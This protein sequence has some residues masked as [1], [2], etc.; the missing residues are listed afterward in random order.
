[1]PAFK[2]DIVYY[3]VGGTEGKWREAFPGVFPEY[4]SIDELIDTITRAGYHA[5]RG[6]KAIGA[7]EGAP[8]G[9]A[10]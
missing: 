4:K 5:V 10:S 6:T 9:G 7:P 8:E 2:Y 1:M 3:W